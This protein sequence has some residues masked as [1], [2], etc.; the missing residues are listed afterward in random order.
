MFTR[1]EANSKIPFFF[2]FVWLIHYLF[3]RKNIFWFNYNF[4]LEND[5]KKNI[6]IYCLLNRFCCLKR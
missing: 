5:G 2:Y 6:Y 3:V 1:E 4:G